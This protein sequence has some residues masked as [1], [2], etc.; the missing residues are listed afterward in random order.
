[1]RENNII[2][3]ICIP[4]YNRGERLS[5]T[6][7]ELLKY[8][9]DD[10]EVIILDD[11]STDGSITYLE[12]IQDDRLQI[13]RNR[14]NL[15]QGKNQ[16]KALFSGHGKYTMALMDRDYIIAGQLPALLE[17]LRSHDTPVL[18]LGQKKD[19]WNS[20]ARQYFYVACSVTHPSNVIVHTEK[21]KQ[22]VELKTIYRLM[23]YR[24]SPFLYYPPVVSLYLLTAYGEYSTLG[25]DITKAMTKGTNSGDYL[26]VGGK[27]TDY[28]LP[29]GAWR[30]LQRYYYILHS[31]KPKEWEQL[32]PWVYAAELHRATLWNLEMY[33]APDSGKRAG[34]K[35]Y[36]NNQYYEYNKELKE[37]TLRLLKKEGQLHIG[38]Y[39]EIKF[40]AW[41]NQKRITTYL[42]EDAGWICRVADKVWGKLFYSVG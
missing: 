27:C 25:C 4:T 6:V 18:L 41:L 12:E 26:S 11:A 19:V 21:L 24:E 14:N 40:L 16:A 2:L 10:I 33:H 13:R 23:R 30:R 3:S 31:Q 9:G 34:I 15:G 1:M 35:R 17:Q 39:Y 5:H 28:Y 36:E 42:E 7:R 22:T 8:A 37:K 32:F 20:S 38:I 29:A